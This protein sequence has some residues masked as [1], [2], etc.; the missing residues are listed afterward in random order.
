[1]VPHWLLTVRR[2]PQVDLEQLTARSRSTPW[3]LEPFREW[4]AAE[5]SRALCVLAGAGS[6]KSSV[7]AAL[8]TQV[9]LAQSVRA[10]GASDPHS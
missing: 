9:G 10:A 2:H 1:M 7:S 8:L 5:G 3:A 6:G 4:M